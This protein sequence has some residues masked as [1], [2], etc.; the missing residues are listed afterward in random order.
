MKRLTGIKDLNQEILS[1]ISD[2]ELLKVC[3]INR[4]F[5]YK[6]CDDAFLKRRLQKYNLSQ[7]EP[8]K[9]FFFNVLYCIPKM[10]KMGLDYTAG[11]LKKQY[12]LL[13]KYR[14]YWYTEM[15]VEA[16]IIGEISLVKYAWQKGSSYR[17]EEAARRATE[18]GHLDIVQFLLEKG[19]DIH[20]S[21]DYLLRIACRNGHFDLVKYLVDEGANIYAYDGQ[22]IRWAKESNHLNIVSYLTEKSIPLPQSKVIN[23]W[24]K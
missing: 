20:I 10:K 14:N 7:I 4:Y 8:G 22:A 2:E 3:S 11:N 6:V 5:Y 18:N 15:L 24:E 17:I 1:Y 9:S 16:A 13:E 12:I 21:G 23:S 19:C